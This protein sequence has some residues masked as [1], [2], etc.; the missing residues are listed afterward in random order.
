MSSASIPLGSAL[1]SERI[2]DSRLPCVEG[3]VNFFSGPT[4]HSRPHSHLHTSIYWH[5][6]C[7]LWWCGDV[8]RTPGTTPTKG[9]LL[10]A[11]SKE[12]IGYETTTWGPRPD[13]R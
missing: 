4:H 13:R 9:E 5:K 1:Y 2:R 12:N 7:D 11:T 10:C 3:T 8:A 6:T